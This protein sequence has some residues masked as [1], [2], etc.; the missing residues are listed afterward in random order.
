MM[1][2]PSETGFVRF[3]RPHEQIGGKLI[4]NR[5]SVFKQGFF[6]MSKIADTLRVLAEPCRVSAVASKRRRMAYR[7]SG[8]KYRA[9]VY[10]ESSRH[11]AFRRLLE[12]KSSKAVKPPCKSCSRKGEALERKLS[13]D[14]LSD[15]QRESETQKWRNLVQKNSARSRP[16][17]LKT[18]ICAANEE[19]AALQ[20]NANRV[21]VDLAKREVTTSSCR[22]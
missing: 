20:Q 19:F 17:W 12:K 13:G 6:I 9:R 16:S 1:F 21:I 3:R 5:P 18:T 10:Q 2:R 22:T 15:S 4:A 11:K 14:K 7:K 8:F